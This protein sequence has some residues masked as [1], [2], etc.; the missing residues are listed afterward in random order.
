MRS[1]R[2]TCKRDGRSRRR[3]RR[4]RPE[5]RVRDAVARRDD[6]AD[7]RHRPAW[8]RRKPTRASPSRLRPAERDRL[9]GDLRLG[10]PHLL[11]AAHAASRSRRRLR[12]RDGA[13]AVQRRAERP[14][15]RGHALFLLEPAREPRP[16]QALGLAHLPVLHDERRRGSSPRSADISSRPARTASPSISMAASRRTS[17]SAGRRSHC[18]RRAI[19]RGP[20]RSGSRST[21]K[22]RRPSISCCAFPAGLASAKAT[23]NGEPVPLAATSGYA[24]IHRRWSKGDVVALTCR[25][26]PSAC[27]RTPTCAWTSGGWR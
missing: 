5:A 17:P 1:G 16:A 25:C 18:A 4:R 13:G 7:V 24:T 19:I 2:C 21:R 11:G 15:A 9:R 3:A 6:G 22:R 27:T 23:V 14:V 12:R 8:A 26:R 20:A 10:R